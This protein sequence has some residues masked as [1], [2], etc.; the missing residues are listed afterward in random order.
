[1]L[2]SFTTSAA[3]RGLSSR[4]FDGTGSACVLG[5][6]TVIYGRNGSGKTTFSEVLRLSSSGA[7]TEGVT[8]TASIRSNN[9][10]SS[11]PL[12]DREFPW[13][14]LVYNRYYVQ[15][16]L[17]LFL[18]GSG[19][20]PTILKLGATNV[21]AARDLVRVRS[22]LTALGQRREGLTVMRRSLLSQRE[23]TEKEVKSE[24]IAARLRP[25]EWCGFPLLSVASSM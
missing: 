1:M 18:D 7:D 25:R 5:R 22:S 21:F 19:R 6:R 14:L 23:T 12:G 16:S 11:I 2:R 24:V 3:F 8:T 20:S 4:P 15:E 17:G 9:S 13:A 10:T